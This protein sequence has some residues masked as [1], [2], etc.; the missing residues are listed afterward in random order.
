MA[1]M[2]VEAKR[3]S[4]FAGVNSVEYNLLR[5]IKDLTAHLEVSVCSGK[6]WEKTILEGFKVWRELKEHSGGKIL[7]DLS[8]KTFEFIPDTLSA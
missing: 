1:L 6:Q 3:N 5:T 8:K 4:F 2:F 7:G